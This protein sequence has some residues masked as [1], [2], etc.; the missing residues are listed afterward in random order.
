MQMKR[1]ILWSLALGWG[2]FSIS[3]SRT[4]A[5]AYL[6]ASGST[7]AALSLTVVISWACCVFCF[8]LI[9]LTRRD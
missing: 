3:A 8:I 9:I 6:S 7:L 4:L 5:K 1:W 2:L